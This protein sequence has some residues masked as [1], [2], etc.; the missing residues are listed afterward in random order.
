MYGY[1]SMYLC[2]MGSLYSLY[3]RCCRKV[4]F[5]VTKVKVEFT[6]TDV[7]VEFIVRKV[8]VEFTVTKVKV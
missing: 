1:Y 2:K 3:S 6:V 7:K 8:K 5:T 4:E